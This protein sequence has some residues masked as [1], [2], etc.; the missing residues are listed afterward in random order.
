MNEQD[1][2]VAAARLVERSGVA[3][4]GVNGSD[5]YP[6]IKAMFKLE[7][8][9]LHTLWFSTNTSSQRVQLLL[10]D[11]RASLCFSDPATVEGL[12]LVG[13]AQVITD[14]LT[15]KRRF[16]SDGCEL[17]YP[18]GVTDPDYSVLQFT[19]KWGRYYHKLQTASFSL[20]PQTT[21]AR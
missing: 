3:M 5:G 15:I 19:A 4:V 13:D 17:Y 21:E 12:M 11:G 20:Q 7:N 10:R 18:L 14:D 2:R 9:G 6:W 16:W 1:M 8:E